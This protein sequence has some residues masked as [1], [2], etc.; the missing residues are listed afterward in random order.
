MTDRKY[1]FLKDF[2]RLDDA[3]DKEGGGHYVLPISDKEVAR[4]EMQEFIR[5]NKERQLV[6]HH[7][8]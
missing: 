5:Q 1:T 6:Q 3:V 2:G 7:Q 8:N 4:K